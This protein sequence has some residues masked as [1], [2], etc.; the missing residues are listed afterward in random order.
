ML[1]TPTLCY[2]DPQATYRKI[3]A[4]HIEVTTALDPE[5]KVLDIDEVKNREIDATANMDYKTVSCDTEIQ[6]QNAEIAKFHEILDQAEALG[7]KPKPEG[8]G[9][10]PAEPTPDPLWQPF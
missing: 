9:D 5:V 2:A 7:I 1:L 8:G 3:D 10:V 6:R 4:T